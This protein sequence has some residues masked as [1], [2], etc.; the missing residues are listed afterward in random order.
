[1]PVIIPQ[2][3]GRAA[4]VE[5]PTTAYLSSAYIEGWRV[6]GW[7][8]AVFVA[9]SMLDLFLGWIPIRFGSPEW[10]FGVVSATVGA[11]SIPTIGL[12]FMLC[13]AISRERVGAAKAVGIAMVVMAVVLLGL[14]FFY[15]TTV[16]LAL[17]TVAA[18]D[19]ASLNMK[20]AILK[21]MVLFVGY[22]GLYIWG[23]IKGLRR[24]S[25]M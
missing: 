19:T 7:L 25:A 6:L 4:T 9:M 16:P 15:L 3:S 18:N 11:L 10:E 20:K 22:E 2:E 1:M 13:S 24:T 14:S 23:G 17:R 21:W 12:Y 5:R 8:G